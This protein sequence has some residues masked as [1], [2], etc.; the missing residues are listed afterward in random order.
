MA[1]VQT[2]NFHVLPYT[3]ISTILWKPS[4]MWLSLSPKLESGNT[5]QHPQ[6]DFKIIEVLCTPFLNA[7]T[8]T[9]GPQHYFVNS[10]L[11]HLVLSHPSTSFL[12][13]S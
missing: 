5:I 6:S 12:K 10:P 8:E 11:F 1:A 13:T 4:S 2:V 9:V 3:V 7:V